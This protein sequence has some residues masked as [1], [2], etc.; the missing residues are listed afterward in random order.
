[1][2]GSTKRGE[3]PEWCDAGRQGRG[4]RGDMRRTR[5]AI[6]A[7]EGQGEGKQKSESGKRAGEECR[8]VSIQATGAGRVRWGGLVGASGAAHSSTCKAGG[9]AG[10]G[11]ASSLFGAGARSGAAGGSRAVGCTEEQDGSDEKWVVCVCDA[12]RQPGRAALKSARHQPQASWV[13][14]EGPGQLA[15]VGKG[16]LVTVCRLSGVLLASLALPQRPPAGSGGG[17]HVHLLL[18]LVRQGARHALTC[19][20]AGGSRGGL[21]WGW[22][23]D[24]SRGQLQ[25]I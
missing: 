6:K 14:G 8:L 11:E 18:R 23:L 7:E 10:S 24:T 1:M 16:S 12:Q 17:H 21:L 4:Q 13:A 9:A 2:A 15:S 5:R 22:L 20:A 19:A 25:L 3:Q